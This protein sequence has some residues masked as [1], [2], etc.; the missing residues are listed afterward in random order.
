[1]FPCAHLL[2][3]YAHPCFVFIS[4]KY[5]QSIGDLRQALEKAS[6]V[7]VD[8]QQLF[9]RGKE[10][11]PE[12]DNKTLLELSMHTGFSLHCYDLVG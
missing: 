10:C 1:M 9:F 3:T 5:S 4:Q 2:C 8:K 6:G 11:L 7:P 12:E